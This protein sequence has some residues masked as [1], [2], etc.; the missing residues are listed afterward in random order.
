MR[1]IEKHYENTIE[2]IYNRL[3]DQHT[4]CPNAICDVITLKVNIAWRAPQLQDTSQYFADTESDSSSSYTHTH[5]R[6]I[7]IYKYVSKMF[8]QFPVLINNFTYS[9]IH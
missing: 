3:N 4:V 1:N 9:S 6:D 7:Y 8:I 5:T 2:E